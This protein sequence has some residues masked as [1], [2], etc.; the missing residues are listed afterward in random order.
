M[1]FINFLP[2]EIDVSHNGVYF[3]GAGQNRGLNLSVLLERKKISFFNQ[4][5]AGGAE[6]LAFLPQAVVRKEESCES[7]ELNMIHC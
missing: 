5:P 4:Y 3:T 2:R 1:I 7:I 6:Q